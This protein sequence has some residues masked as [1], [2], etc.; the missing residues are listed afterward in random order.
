MFAEAHHD[1][2]LCQRKSQTKQ[3]NNNISNKRKAHLYVVC[4]TGL[5]RVVGKVEV[6]EGQPPRMASTGKAQVEGAVLGSR[7]SVGKAGGP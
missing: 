5:Q 3:G 7:V 2:I 1:C 4:V 6:S